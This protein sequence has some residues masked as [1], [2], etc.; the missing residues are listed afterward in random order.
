MSYLFSILTNDT[1]LFRLTVEA[2][3]GAVQA[4]DSVEKGYWGLGYYQ[5]G[6]V[7]LQKRPVGAKP[8][9]GETIGSLRTNRLL[10]HVQE[11]PQIR[12]DRLDTQPFR[13]RSWAFALSGT[14]G[15]GGLVREKAM[16]QIPDYL[17]QNIEGSLAP[18]LVFHIFLGRL[19]EEAK[20]PVQRTEPDR[21][22]RALAR[23]F[24]LLP[25]LAEE[26]G[27]IGFSMVLT[28]GVHSFGATLGRPLHYRELKGV[29]E[30]VGDG[31]RIKRYEWVRSILISN[32]V[33]S[34]EAELWSELPLGHLL[35]CD[36]TF[37]LRLLPLE[38]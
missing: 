18:E 33:P 6:R 1:Q 20:L 10:C 36:E 15:G 34:A 4:M 22:R 28:D 13:Y 5:D 23:T 26:H 27:E 37:D 11:D 21:I 12:F 2:A 14:L 9:I 3:S 8:S 25:E 17:R 24:D 35:V 32:R 30:S 29:E 7:L 16:A 31:S 38:S 19:Y